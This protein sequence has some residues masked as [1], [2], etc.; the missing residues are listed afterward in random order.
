MGVIATNNNNNSDNNTNNTQQTVVTES[1]IVGMG[2][3]Q[4]QPIQTG[5]PQ[6]QRLSYPQTQTAGSLKAKSSHSN[7]HSHSL[8][9]SQSHSRS[10]LD[11]VDIDSSSSSEVSHASHSAADDDLYTFQ[12]EMENPQNDAERTFYSILSHLKTDGYILLNEC[13]KIT[14]RGHPDYTGR[15]EAM[16]LEK[17]TSSKKVCVTIF[18]LAS[19]IPNIHEC[20]ILNDVHNHNGDN[21]QFHEGKRE[22]VQLVLSKKHQQYKAQKEGTKLFPVGRIHTNKKVTLWFPKRNMQF[23]AIER[24]TSGRDVYFCRYRYDKST[25]TLTRIDGHDEGPSSDY[26]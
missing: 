23:K 1:G 12:A 24:K 3:S 9:T 11:E 14:R 7:T 5:Y 17:A 13:I 6:S 8:S 2:H 25:K 26:Q 15:V 20:R 21:K 16:F 4:S 22:Y 10:M 18:Q 19:D